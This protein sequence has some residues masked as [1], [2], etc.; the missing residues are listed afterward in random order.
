MPFIEYAIYGFVDQLHEHIGAIKWQKW[1]TAWV[2]YVH[3]VMGE[4]K[5]PAGRRQLKLVLAMSKHGAGA[6]VDRRTIR[7]L[8]PELAEEYAE[9]TSKTITRD[10]NALLQKTL[11]KKVDGKYEPQMEQILAFLPT[12]KMGA[13]DSSKLTSYPLVSEEGGQLSLRF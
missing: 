9:K 10:L 1:Q 12:R 6:A 13:D 3:E 7:R 5:T 2:N 8:T 4:P 11:I